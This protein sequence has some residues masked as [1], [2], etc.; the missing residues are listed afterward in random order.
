MFVALVKPTCVYSRVF[1]ASPHCF[2]RLALVSPRSRVFFQDAR[3]DQVPWPALY[4]H[5][6]RER[7]T[8]H[9]PADRGFIVRLHAR[10]NAIMPWHAN[11]PHVTL[12]NR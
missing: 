12:E 2:W 1:L 10:A 7:L 6:A 9:V 3:C 8:F 4:R 5:P 11:L